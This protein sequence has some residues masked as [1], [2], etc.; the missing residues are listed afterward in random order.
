MHGRAERGEH[1]HVHLLLAVCA[2]QQDHGNLRAQAFRDHE[3][4]G[5]ADDHVAGRHE[6]RHVLHV[7]EHAHVG[8][9]Q[10]G[11]FLPQVAGVIGVVAGHDDEVHVRKRVQVGQQLVERVAEVHVGTRQLRAGQRQHHGLVLRQAQALARLPLVVGAAEI[12]ARGDACDADALLGHAAGAQRLGHGLVRHAEQVGAAVRPEALGLV[13]GGH[14]HDGELQAREHARAH[15]HVRRRDVG[16]HDGQRAHLAHVLGESGVHDARPG[17]AA[18]P[19]KAAGEREAPGEIVD[20]ARGSREERCGVVAVEHDAAPVQDVDDLDFQVLGDGDAGKRVMRRIGT[21]RAVCGISD[22]GS[23]GRRLVPQQL[24]GLGHGH[25]RAAMARA[26]GRMHDDDARLGR[27][28]RRLVARGLRGFRQCGRGGRR[29]GC[30]GRPRVPDRPR[31]GLLGGVG[32]IDWGL[33]PSRLV[34]VHA[35]IIPQRPRL[36]AISRS[37]GTRI[38]GTSGTLPKADRPMVTDS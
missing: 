20:R 1:P 28:G 8:K 11:A 27:R 24:E 32:A 6:R 16:A 3:A 10:I 14:A 4:A 2:A 19:Q 13:V 26:H 18:G 37:A 9:S 33:R 5:L 17:G 30:I 21:G 25:G 7:V 22:T 34:V 31:G 15:G 29:V 12:L 35:S 38:H 36:R 23:G